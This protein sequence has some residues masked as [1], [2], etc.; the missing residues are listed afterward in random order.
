[1][2]LSSKVF[3]GFLM[4]AIVS[5]IVGVIGFNGITSI[6]ELDQKTYPENLSA[7]E[8]KQILETE[9]EKIS[10]IIVFVSSMSI[11]IAI[12]FGLYFSTLIGIPLKKLEITAKEIGKGN[13]N[14][15]FRYD[16]DDE[17]GEFAQTFNL[18]TD[19]LKK[20]IELEKELAISKQKIKNERLTTIDELS[21]RLAHDIRNPLTVIQLNYEL[22]KNSKNLSDKEKQHFQRV[23]LSIQRIVHQ[24]NDV[25]DFVREKPL[26]LERNSLL[27][28][29]NSTLEDIQI[30]KNI[31]VEKP[32]NDLMIL[33]DKESLTIVFINIITNAIQ[34]IG[35]SGTIKIRF[36][37]NP[38]QYII[39]VED[40]GKGILDEDLQKIF[41]PI[42]TT[43]QEGTGL[44]LTS[45]KS[46]IE[47]HGGTISAKNNPTTFT[48]IIS[49]KADQS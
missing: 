9:S 42:F 13:L 3:A 10:G 45:C 34:V 33:S 44:G 4:L 5:S 28:I 30:P 26:K 39:E 2:K 14:V 8:E 32:S 11:I 7:D 16:K 31:T 20:V 40:T 35:K 12:G 23:D 6:I 24:I 25:L 47:Q 18:M 36:Q 46:I 43:K 19:S 41:D 21:S 48:M 22:L 27:D 49:K 29:L 38:S 17:I 37:E 1:M 15:K